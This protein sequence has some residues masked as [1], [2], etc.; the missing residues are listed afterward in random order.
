MS[1]LE[2]NGKYQEIHDNVVHIRGSVSRLDQTIDRLS[3]SVD[4]LS[5]TFKN[6][7]DLNERTIKY[8]MDANEKTVNHVKNSLPLRVVLILC[9]IIVVAF[10]GGGILKEVLDAD[11]LTKVIP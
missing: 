11:I 5:T 4:N 6:S 1:P 8:V 3:I 9:S 10:A 7:T 2:T